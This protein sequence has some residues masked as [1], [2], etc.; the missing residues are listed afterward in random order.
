MLTDSDLAA[1]RQA[2]EAALPETATIKRAT[3]TRTASGGTTQSWATAGTSACRLSSR[4]VP[5]EYLEAGAARGVQYWM[6]TM[7][8][9]TNVTREDQLVIGARTLE[10]VGFASGGAWQTALRAVCV[11]VG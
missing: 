3:N 1:M 10:V 11:E 4:G 7:P 8:H 5:R 2:Q 9:G 6:V